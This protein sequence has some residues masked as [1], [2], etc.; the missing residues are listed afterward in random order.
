MESVYG[1]QEVGTDGLTAQQRKFKEDS[2]AYD[3]LVDEMILKQ[4]DDVGFESAS[5]HSASRTRK[6]EALPLKG[7]TT[8]R[9]TRS[10]STLRSREAA[11]ALS[12]AR[13][14]KAPV[15]APAPKSRA[16]SLASSASSLVMPKRHAR[17]PSNPSSMRSTAASA[18]SRTT[19][20]YS[21]GRTVSSD[22]REKIQA[23][24]PSTAQALSPEIYMKLYGPPPLDS[25]MWTRCKA[26][27]CF[28][29]EQ[30]SHELE[31]LSTFDEDEEA[32]SFQ[33]TL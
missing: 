26:A 25:E 5:E 6:P 1:K 4:L 21:K 11:I 2:L 10:V 23:Q 9:H 28:D 15:P 33:L 19:V 29:T 22:L 17:A 7:P 32:D 13:P 27:G 31:E 30:A 20:G 18:N 24:K 14:D 16:A 8:I 12:G 3:Q